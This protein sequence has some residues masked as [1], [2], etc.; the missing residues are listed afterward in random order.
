[1]SDES[2]QSLVDPQLAVQ[3]LA[4]SLKFDWQE[5]SLVWRGWP[6]GSVK[7]AAEK[8][9][10]TTLVAVAGARHK[11]T[12]SCTVLT[13]SV[14]HSVC[15]GQSLVVLLTVFERWHTEAHCGP[16]PTPTSSHKSE[17]QSLPVVHASPMFFVPRTIGV[18]VWVVVLQV[19]PLEHWLG[20]VQFWQVFD[21]HTR[22]PLHCA[23]LLHV[24]LGV[25][26]WLA[27][28]ASPVRQ[29]LELTQVGEQPLGKHACGEGQSSALPHVW[30][31]GA[32]TECPGST[33]ES[34]V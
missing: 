14:T 11:P 25:H 27:L 33:L 2:R 29:S 5:V 10:P 13:K 6:A 18:H 8:V 4:A 9:S 17:A 21:K 16:T 20:L 22:P 7:F 3:K 1:M 32:Q 26:T 23:L 31:E 34:H 24:A 28:H 15:S 30:P 12:P 19:F